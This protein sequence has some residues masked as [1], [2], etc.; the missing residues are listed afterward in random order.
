MTGEVRPHPD[1]TWIPDVAPQQAATQA[2][3]GLAREPGARG[4]AGCAASC[5]ECRDPRAQASAALDWR[6]LASPALPVLAP[7]LTP[8]RVVTAPP[9]PSALIRPEA[10]QAVPG[11]HSFP[12][13]RAGRQEGSVP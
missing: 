12:G 6:G 11:C 2:G 7:D 13:G 8:G 1:H 5:L 9:A 10:L 4:P 3:V